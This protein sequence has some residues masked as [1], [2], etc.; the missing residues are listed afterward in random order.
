MKLFLIRHAETEHNVKQARAGATDSSLTNHGV[1]QIQRLA[2]YLRSRPVQFTRVFCSD[3]QRARLTAEGICQQQLGNYPLVPMQTSLLQE[4][5]FGLLEGSRWK[6]RAATSAYTPNAAVPGISPSRIEEESEDSMR[7]RAT[8]FLRDYILP[9]LLGS[10]PKEEVVAVV[11]HGIILRVLWKCITDLFHPSDILISSEVETGVVPPGSPLIAVW[12]NT[13]FMELDIRPKPLTAPSG[14][15]PAPI[16][17]GSPFS[18]WQM[19]LLSVNNTSHL[20]DL[21]RTGG[22]IGS[23]THDQRQRTLDGFFRTTNAP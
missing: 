14:I 9:L 15:L 23:A 20:L 6:P 2:Q 16:A 7:A 3:L 10:S 5:H 22:G 1:L 4:Q 17:T 18:G 13:G 11:A 8:S 12:S 21:R 19:L